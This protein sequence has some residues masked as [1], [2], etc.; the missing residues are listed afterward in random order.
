LSSYNL[1]GHNPDSYRGDF[2]VTV[3][4]MHLLNLFANRWPYLIRNL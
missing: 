3:V 1:D 2:L 4:T